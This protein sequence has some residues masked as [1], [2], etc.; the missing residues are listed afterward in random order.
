MWKVRFL[1]IDNGGFKFLKDLK[2]NVFSS[3]TQNL[4]NSKFVEY[5]IH[6]LGHDNEKVTRI[7]EIAEKELKVYVSVLK[8]NGYEG[9]LK[10]DYPCK[11]NKNGTNTVFAFF[12]DK[13]NI[14]DSI[15]VFVNGEVVHSSYQ[16]KISNNKMLLENALANTTK[17]E[18]LILLGCEQNWINAYKIYEIL[19]KHLKCEAELKKYDELKY[20]AHSANSPGAIGIDN[21]RHAVQPHQNPKKIANINT[22]YNKLVDLSLEFITQNT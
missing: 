11:I 20:F 6:I 15:E 5:F 9:N 13:L 22:S 2:D 4:N 12:E 17:K 3:K 18:L 1:G 8:L 7:L 16:V 21:A 14:T 19:K 10:P